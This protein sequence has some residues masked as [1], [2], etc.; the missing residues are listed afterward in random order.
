MNPKLV[1]QHIGDVI[2]QRRKQL[3]LR[4]HH[5]AAKLGISRGSLANIEIG[6]QGVLVHQLYKFGKALNLPPTDFL[7]LAFEKD[8][9]EWGNVK[10]PDDLSRQQK[11]QIAA[12]IDGASNALKQKGGRNA[13]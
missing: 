11:S 5:L 9:S 4:Q 3:G 6:A 1:Y 2:R 13:K 10:M 12:L 7:P 8:E